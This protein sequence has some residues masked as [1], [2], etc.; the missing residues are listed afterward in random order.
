MNKL[1]YLGKAA[2]GYGWGVLNQNLIEALKKYCEVE[3]CQNPKRHRYDAPIFVPGGDQLQCG[4]MIRAPMVIGY[5]VFEMP[6]G[7]AAKWNAKRYDWIFTPSEWCANRVRTE[8]AASHVSC[9]Y[10]GVDLE[11]FSPQ[12]YD[13]KRK[14]FRVFS[15]G[16]W[17]YRKAQDIVIAAMKIFLSQRKDSVLVTMWHNPWPD[18]MSSMDKSYLIG[19]EP[20]E[21]MDPKKLITIPPASNKQLGRIYAEA[22]VGLF[23]N[24]CEGATNMIMMEFMACQR[25]VIATRATGQGEILDKDYP[26]ALTQGSWDEAGWFN[27]DVS[28]LLVHLEKA[29]NNREDL[30]ALGVKCRKLI[31]PYTWDATAKQIALKA[32]GEPSA[33]SHASA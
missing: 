7:E 3:V 31:E 18:T 13:E 10:Q 11:R 5:C 29:Y 16:K 17:E 14:G 32:F 22:D 6:L 27:T 2:D 20:F 30:R 21:G 24:R 9:L 28:D 4:K 8:A 15:G 33:A 25:P 12:P 26:L 23:P 1:Y 19:K